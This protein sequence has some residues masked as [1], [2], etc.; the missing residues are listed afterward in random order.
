MIVS[1]PCESFNDYEILPCSQLASKDKLEL[2]RK[3]IFRFL[4]SI[5]EGGFG[6]VE[7]VQHKMDAR[8]YALKTVPIHLGVQDDICLHSGYKEIQAI[9]RLC[10][11]NIVRYYSSWVEPVMP[12]QAH[13]TKI[14]R[15]LKKHS[16]NYQDCKA[17]LDGDIDE[18]DASSEEGISDLRQNE[19]DEGLLI[20]RSCDSDQKDLLE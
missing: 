17:Y 1:F 3:E 12:D 18:E 19:L 6:K 10:H 7:K 5:G 11:K 20:V 2:N 15:Y 14:I 8:T 13:L 9:S 16:K 4:G